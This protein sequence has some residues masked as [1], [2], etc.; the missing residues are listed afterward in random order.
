M[1][2]LCFFINDEVSLEGTIIS[3]VILSLATFASFTLHDTEA[4]CTIS[5]TSPETTASKTVLLWTNSSLSIG[6]FSV[7]ANVAARK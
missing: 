4:A 5:F 6:G 7:S 2:T 1:V 3:D